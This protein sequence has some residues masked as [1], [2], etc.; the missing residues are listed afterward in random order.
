M[1]YTFRLCIPGLVNIDTFRWISSQL[2]STRKYSLTNEPTQLNSLTKRAPDPNSAQ[3]NK[4]SSWLSKL[5]KLA[6]KP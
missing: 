6:K 4:N 1:Q 2:N 3:L 5:I